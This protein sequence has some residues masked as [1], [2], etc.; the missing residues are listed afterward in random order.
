MLLFPSQ[1]EDAGD[2][3]AEGVGPPDQGQELPPQSG[4]AAVSQDLFVSWRLVQKQNLGMAYASAQQDP[5]R[6]HNCL[7][8]TC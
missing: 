7:N 2:T 8:L 4:V 3:S 1:E 6:F 5:L